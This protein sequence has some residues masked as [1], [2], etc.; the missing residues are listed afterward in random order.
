MK[1]HQKSRY[2]AERDDGVGPAVGLACRKASR[3]SQ[4]AEQRFKSAV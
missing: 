3:N 4:M 1:V 2:S